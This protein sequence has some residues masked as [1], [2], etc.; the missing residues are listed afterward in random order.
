MHAPNLLLLS[1]GSTWA[2]WSALANTGKVVAGLLDPGCLSPVPPVLGCG[3]KQAYKYPP[4][5]W[6]ALPANFH[7]DAETPALR[8]RYL[9]SDV[10]VDCG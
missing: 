6:R 7:I 10:S 9:I 5:D 3:R 2:Y 4:M 8:R 1:V